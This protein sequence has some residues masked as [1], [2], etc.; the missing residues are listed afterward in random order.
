VVILELVVLTDEPVVLQLLDLLQK[1]RI[2]LFL[3]Q[4]PLQGISLD[5]FV[6][7]FVCKV[8]FFII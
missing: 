1:D 5:N 6:L 8:D 2:L 7:V 3:L 4:A